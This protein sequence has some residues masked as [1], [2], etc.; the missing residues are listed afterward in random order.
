[1][2]RALVGVLVAAFTAPACGGRGSPGKS[3]G[4]LAPDAAP[5]VVTSS[6]FATNGDIPTE[7]TC[8][9]EG[10]SPPLQWGDA[11]AGTQSF[12]VIVDDP[13]APDPAK[14]ERVYLHWLVYDIPAGVHA[15]DAGALPEGARV[16]KN[17]EGDDEWTPPCPPT[18]R[19]RYFHRVYALDTMLGDLDEPDRATL[20]AAMKPHVL[21]TGHIVGTYAKS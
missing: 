13:D 17:E 3:S 16:G 8:D 14:P 9:G 6:A 2:Q 21:A 4:P 12:A 10:S 18:G 1:M 7:Y 20:E 11:P 5:L 15:L 19:H